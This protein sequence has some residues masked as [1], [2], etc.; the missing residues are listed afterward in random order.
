[1]NITHE[2]TAKCRERDSLLLVDKP[3]GFSSFQIVRILKKRY[4]KVGHAGTLDPFASGL[5]IILLN[6]ATK[7]FDNIQQRDKEYIGAMI[8]GI[9]TDTY[10][11]TGA[12]TGNSKIGSIDM[13]LDELNRAAQQFVGEIEQTPPRYSALKRDGKKLYQLTRQ[14]RS[15]DIAPRKVLVKSF[16]IV[17]VDFP[18]LTFR[19]TVGRGVYLRSLAHD[20]GNVLGC[21]GT[22]VS[23]RRT[24]IGAY[25][26]AQAEKI[27][28][29]LTPKSC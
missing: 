4:E 27:G 5:L 21:G 9:S 15:I 22:L 13:T 19:S 23:L 7:Q 1:L 2:I 14:N 28:A 16:E 24:R 10:D 25:H 12:Q 11:I 18:I 26:V 20:F 29:I 8:L 17:D 6:R 3:I